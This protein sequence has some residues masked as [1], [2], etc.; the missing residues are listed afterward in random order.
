MV[1]LIQMKGRWLFPI[2]MP[3]LDVWNSMNW[4]WFYIFVFWISVYFIS[5]VLVSSSSR[6]QGEYFCIPSQSS[7]AFTIS[8]IFESTSW[9]ITALIFC[10][11]FVTKTIQLYTCTFEE[12]YIIVEANH[13]KTQLKILAAWAMVIY[14]ASVNKHLISTFCHVTNTTGVLLAWHSI[15]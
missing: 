2:S 4:I 11:K 10:T 5:L 12:G 6:V 7:F 15:M 9:T 3:Q 1:V 14:S 13:R 8:L